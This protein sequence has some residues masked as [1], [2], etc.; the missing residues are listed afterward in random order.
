MT[1]E[2]EKNNGDTELKEDLIIL[3]LYIY[4]SVINKYLLTSDIKKSKTYAKCMIIKCN[5]H[6][7][8]LKV[9]SDKLQLWIVCSGRVDSLHSSPCTSCT[10]I[11]CNVEMSFH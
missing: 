6:L 3:K 9:C 8:R 10:D 4:R 7:H 2:T 5:I 11:S 1:G